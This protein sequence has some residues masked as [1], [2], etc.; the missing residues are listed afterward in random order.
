VCHSGCG[1]FAERP[2]DAGATTLYVYSIEIAPEYGGRGSAARR[3][4]LFEDEARLRGLS[5]ANLT[6]L[7]GNE[8]ARSLYRSLG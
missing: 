6:V 3:C 4:K 7:G 5:E 1:Q 8:V 2:N